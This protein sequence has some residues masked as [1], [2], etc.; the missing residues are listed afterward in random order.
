MFGNVL[1]KLYIPEVQKVSGA[2]EKKI[3]QVGMTKLLT[4]CPAMLN[5][6]KHYW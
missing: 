5:E 6:Y 3:C 2:L 1:E 4:E